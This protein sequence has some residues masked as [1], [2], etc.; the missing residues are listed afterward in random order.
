MGLI[1][2]LVF[3]TSVMVLVQAGPQ[4]AGVDLGPDR[5]QQ[6][7]PRENITYDHVLTNTGAITDTFS[8]DVLSTQGW[9]VG[10]TSESHPT[11]TQVLTLELGAQMST[12]LQVSLTVPLD[13]SGVR[14]VT[15]IT[16]TSQ[17]SP[18]VQDTAVDTTHVPA[19]VY[20]PLLMRRWPP[21]P[22]QPTI[23]P[24]SNDDGNG[25]YRVRW[26]EGPQ[27]LGETYTLQ[28][29]TNRAF[30]TELREVCA[31]SQQHCD[32]TGKSAGTYYYRVRGH[33]AYGYGPYSNEQLATVPPP[34]HPPNATW[35]PYDVTYRIALSTYE[36]ETKV[37]MPVPVNWNTQKEVQLLGYSPVPSDDFIESQGNRIVFWERYLEGPGPHT[38]SEHFQIAS[39]EAEWPIDADSV[40][41]FD[42]FD[43]VLSTYLT[44]TEY[45]QSE[46]QELQEAAASAI[47]NESNPYAQVELLFDFVVQHMNGFS[48]GI[49]DALGAYQARQAE[50]GGYS[51]LFIA[52]CRAVGVP[53]R[54]VTGIGGLR[55]GEHHWGE[56]EVD[57]HVWAEF[58]LPGYGWVPADPIAEDLDGIDALG[59]SFG[60]RLILSK[61]SDIDLRHAITW[62][63]P[64]FHMPYVNTHQEEGEDLV[65]I[66]ERVDW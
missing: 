24:I 29:A 32:V 61:G 20:F 43:P 35:R 11:E 2:A 26:T 28:E 38:F 56:G 40:G 21:L 54:P 1:S 50:C 46:H 53:A 58:Y 55:E 34:Y 47:G 39:L 64:W 37:W 65:L 51:H 16:A 17:L 9:P 36:G 66:V 5:S 63:I 57:T 4:T 19:T 62:G 31:T 14:D 44:P 3:C 60:N 10:L 25:S 22:H 6:A 15:L 42:T 13:A 33:N 7:E 48:P 18:T 12:A 30:T 41:S 49:N 8:V 52:L 27:P 45:I 23:T 59:K